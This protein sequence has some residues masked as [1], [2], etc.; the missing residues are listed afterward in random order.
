MVLAGGL[1]QPAY[2]LVGNYLILA[3]SV[4]LIEQAWQQIRPDPDGETKERRRVDDAAGN[5]FLFVRTGEMIDRLVPLFTSMAKET[6]ERTRVMTAE[7]RLFM[8]EIGL[9]VL[10]SLRN[11]ATS[12]LRG[13]VAGDTIL[14]EGDYTLRRD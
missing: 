1:L 8:R 6:G 14:L 3:D 13:S 10:A 9:P 12:D 7:S 5:L 4:E 2:A 11:V